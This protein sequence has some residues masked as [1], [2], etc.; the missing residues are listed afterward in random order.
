MGAE[1]PGTI[2]KLAA[3]GALPKRKLPGRVRA[4]GFLETDLVALMTTAPAPIPRQAQ[5]ESETA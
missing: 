1:R 4:S 2:D 5:T 3:S